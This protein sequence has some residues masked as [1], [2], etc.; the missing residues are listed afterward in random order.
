MKKTAVIAVVLV[1]YSFQVEARSKGAPA[2]A[3]ATL[4][5]RHRKNQAINESFPY[6]VDLSALASGYEAGKSYKSKPKVAI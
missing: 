5:P 6:E 2:S 4:I 1:L 3:C